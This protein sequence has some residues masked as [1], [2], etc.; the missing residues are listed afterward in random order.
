MKADLATNRK[1]ILIIEDSDKLRSTILQLLSDDYDVIGVNDA[2]KGLASC[3]SFKPDLILLDIMLPGNIDGFSFL[4]II[5]KDKTLSHIPV[6][7]ISALATN[8]KITEGLKLGANDYLIKPFDLT[9]LD[10]KIR[11]QLTISANLKENLLIEQHIPFS[12]NIDSRDL[13]KE[14]EVLLEENITKDQNYS[15]K[16]YA[17]DLN[18]SQSTLERIIKRE[19]G[20]SPNK[21][22]LERKLQKADILLHSNKGISIKEVSFMFGFSSVSYFSRC[23]K[24]VYG[25]PPSSHS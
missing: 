9:Q 3:E 4:R 16:E 6:I 5:K 23:Y 12:I 19:H 13:L 18:I 20:I 11:N 17:N 15:I 22:I 10:L 25:K 24:K 2:S 21:Y 7:I 8:E 1:S 14:F